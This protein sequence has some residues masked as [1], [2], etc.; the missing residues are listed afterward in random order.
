MIDSLPKY[1]WLFTRLDRIENQ[2][3]EIESYGEL[4]LAAKVEERA[5]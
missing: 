2:L 1:Q 4:L 3:R 5:A